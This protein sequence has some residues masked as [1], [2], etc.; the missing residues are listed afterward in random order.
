MTP[1]TTIRPHLSALADGEVRPLEAIAL[2]RH[3]SQ[4]STCRHAFAQ[5]E[6]LKLRVHLSGSEIDPPSGFEGRLAVAVR[7]QSRT[8]EDEDR[9]QARSGW[10]PTFAVAAVAA[11]AVLAT[12]GLQAPPVEPVRARVTLDRAAIVELVQ[13][14]IARTPASNT[15]VARAGALAAFEPLPGTFIT[16]EGDRARMVEASFVDCDGG[17]PGSS[18]AVLE[19]AQLD[20][21]P[22][23][24][25]GLESQGVFVEVIDGVEFRLSLSGDKAFVLLSDI[26]PLDTSPPI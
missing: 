12:L 6:A 9:A 21:P 23:V 22:A 1:C 7:A 14:H 2:R 16:E 3:L 25:A 17:A 8:D 11:V 18:L 20:F 5:V 26:R 13:A 4:C 15:A 19:A 10:W 24:D